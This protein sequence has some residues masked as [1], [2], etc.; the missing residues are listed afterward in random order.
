MNRKPFSKY[1]L[2]AVAAML[3]FVML[4]SLSACGT[5]GV[6]EIRLKSQLSSGEG[7]E[8]YLHAA[9]AADTLKS[10]S[11]SGLV[12]M[13]FDESAYSVCVRDTSYD[14]LW[15]SLPAEENFEAAVA[16]AQIVS[17]N[18]LYEL[19]T[20]D[21][22]VAFGKAKADISKNSVKVTYILT[23]DS[24]T[25]KKESYSDSDIA[26]K[27]VMNYTL[28]DGSLYVSAK[29]KNLVDGSDA[30]LLNLTLLEYFGSD[31]KAEQGDYIFVPD[32]SGALIKL[33]T[34]DEAFEQ[35]LEFEVYGEDVATS[36]G[37]KDKYSAVVPAYG[38]KRGKSAFVI[39]ITD[40]DAI[41]DISA[42][43]V[44]ADNKFFKVG[45]SFDIT[46]NC[47]VGEKDEK[48]IYVSENSYN[49]EIKLCVRFLNGSNANYTG[50]AAA[51]REQFIRTHVLSTKTVS[52]NSEYLPLDLSVIGVADDA[53][54]SV[55][56]FSPNVSK[57]FTDFE[58][59]QDMVLRMKS[60]GINGINLRYKGALS[61]GYN[62]SDVTSASLLHRLGSKGDLEELLSYMTAQ[63]MGVYLDINI[64]SS[65]KSLFGGSAAE[66]IFGDTALYSYDSE[67]SPYIGKSSFKRQLTA[68]KKINRV[69]ID[70]LGNGRFGDFTGLCINDAGSVLYSDFSSKKNRQEVA[71]IISN[72]ITPLTAGRNLMTDTGNFFMIKDV[73]F[74]SHIPTGANAPIS[75]AYESVPFVQLV[76]HG[77]VEYSSQPINLSKDSET[78]ML[79]CV[80]YG[81]CPS[82]EWSYEQ[83]AKDGETD[84]LYYENWIT[85]AADFYTRA[86]DALADVRSSRMT[87]HEE[88]KDGV[89]C[90]EYDTGAMVY[91]NYSQENVVVSGITIPAGDFL[92]IN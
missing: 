34:E 81:A 87:S 21:H 89:F 78:A 31:T 9:S 51:A 27:L 17:D 76:L 19:N 15:T 46:P 80:E 45:A 75:E 8:A 3:A 65:A 86:N 47:I 5:S 44:R 33:D 79:R 11:S 16:K 12:E 48:S 67:I 85:S 59:A 32:G 30:K 92:R 88:I 4:F 55:G 35:P 84:N 36:E 43:R 82:Y 90:T 24:K 72:E 50:M 77:I 41:A 18:K 29:T 74:I 63:N 91:V 28:E 62:Q 40:G 60:K 70:V 2:S 71:D 25:A 42:D 68:T 10:I 69:I 6:S 54:F 38:M 57:T 66:N 20:Q 37:K 7:S 39:L 23:P 83:T 53:L 56:K 26:F 64:L 73:E 61:G 22:S 1:I 52:V 14:R 49:D 13:L 58:Q